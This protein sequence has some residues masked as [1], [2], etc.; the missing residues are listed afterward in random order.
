MLNR[1]E[2]WCVR[3][4]SN[5]NNHFEFLESFQISDLVNCIFF[6]TYNE[7]IYMHLNLFEH[8]LIADAVYILYIPRNRCKN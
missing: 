3:N 8:I 1:I 5:R 2:R 6:S 7:V 4:I